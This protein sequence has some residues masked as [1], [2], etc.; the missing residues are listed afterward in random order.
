M[1]GSAGGR[2][3]LDPARTD[4]S[5]HVGVGKKGN[6]AAPCDEA[7][8]A[9]PTQAATMSEGATPRDDAPALHKEAATKSEGSVSSSPL[10]GR[11]IAFRN[12]SSST[13]SPNMLEWTRIKPTQ[14]KG[15]DSEAP[16]RQRLPPGALE[17]LKAATSSGSTSDSLAFDEGASERP[18]V[19]ASPS[20][21]KRGQ[22]LCRSPQS[23][24]PGSRGLPTRPTGTEP[25][26]AH[27][28]T[29][30]SRSTSPNQDGIGRRS[31]SRTVCEQNAPRLPG[32]SQMPPQPA[33]HSTVSPLVTP[34][35]MRAMSTTA[36]NIIQM[37][38][39][40]NNQRTLPSLQPFA[41]HSTL[42]A[43]QT[44]AF[45]SPTE[46]RH[47]HGTNPSPRPT[48]AGDRT[49]PVTRTSHSQSSTN[50]KLGFFFGKRRDTSASA[51][52]MA[53]P[54]SSSLGGTPCLVPAEYTVIPAEG[55][56]ADTVTPPPFSRT[57][58]FLVEWGDGTA[59]PGQRLEIL[60]HLKNT[61]YYL[62]YFHGRPHS[63]FIVTG[64]PCPAILSVEETTE[65]AD[66]K[67]HLRCLLRTPME[68]RWVFI[69][70]GVKSLKK[71][72]RGA[73][74][75]ILGQAHLVKVVAPELQEEL[76]SFERMSVSK[77]F[78]LGLLYCKPGQTSEEDML[79]NMDGFSED[80]K[81]FLA[82][83]GDQVVLKGWERYR[84]GLDVKTDTTGVHSVFTAFGEYEVMW[85]VATL[86]PHTP[87]DP[88]QVEK[89]R[90]LG[91]DIVLLIFRDRPEDVIDLSTIRSMFN[92][93][94]IIITPVKDK[95][96]DSGATETKYRVSVAFK[97]GV[98]ATPPLL[99]SPPIF[100]KTLPT[101]EFLITKCINCERAC[102]YAPSFQSKIERTK[103]GHLDRLAELFG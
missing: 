101:R 41:D 1:E 23:P 26:L 83:L 59:H 45:T 82:F 7:P 89:K 84:G 48:A 62:Y 96:S 33:M 46:R 4:G 97:E 58:G 13:S 71:A 38:K 98:I 80:Y 87:G 86:L 52:S 9:L 100:P 37:H 88:Q 76:L 53:S 50:L 69:K 63:N 55:Q 67:P 21:L 94:F 20:A 40:S 6:R 65:E 39:E 35:R 85:H 68:D 42:Q 103:K 92:H 27:R 25:S 95:S 99:P 64:G 70:N 74:P 10:P 81:E 34:R 14:R 102:M 43:G 91:N 11:M 78:K 57:P 15:S 2:A 93:A 72:L 73:S 8:P 77:Q 29:I 90:H 54:L 44:G 61:L 79:N 19:T 47:P 66:S 16:K 60:D 3:A 5:F 51:D 36:S 31:R 32:L 24:G 56:P 18:F 49:V 75:D 30:G 28:P 17:L 12:A 22:S